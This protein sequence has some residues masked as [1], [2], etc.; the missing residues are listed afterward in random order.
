MLSSSD[1]EAEAIPSYESPDLVSAL[2]SFGA[3]DLSASGGGVDLLLE[4]AC[5]IRQWQLGGSHPRFVVNHW[6]EVML[7]GADQA[8][9]RVLNAATHVT[10]RPLTLDNL[11]KTIG[12]QLQQVEAHQTAPDFAQRLMAAYDLLAEEVASAGEGLPEVPLHQIYLYLKQQQPTY[13]R[14]HFGLDLFYALEN[15]LLLDR[16]PSLLPDETVPR[17]ERYY[18]P[19]FGLEPQQA[20]PSVHRLLLS[21]ALQSLEI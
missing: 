17:K 19:D 11:L 14:M 10:L 16:N 8:H 9:C 7:V 6:V 5:A 21:P 20:L 12:Q 13:A 15:G 18:L 2:L 3:A 4:K 1:R